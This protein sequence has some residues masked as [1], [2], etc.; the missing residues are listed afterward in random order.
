MLTLPRDRF[1]YFSKLL[2]A[3]QERNKTL[4][5]NI[6]AS[7]LSRSIKL[8]R[9]AQVYVNVDDVK[10]DASLDIALVDDLERPLAGYTAKLSVNSLKAPVQWAG[11]KTLPGNTPFRV[12]ITWPE[13]VDNGK[14]YAIYI[15]QQ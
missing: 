9:P 8:S 10:S 12:K 5:K 4:D 11:K 1:G 2:S 6:E 13:G 15:E 3:S 14:V 7:C